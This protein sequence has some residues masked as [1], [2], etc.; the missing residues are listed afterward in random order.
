MSVLSSTLFLLFLTFNTLRPPPPHHWLHH[1]TELF[2]KSPIGKA[3][4]LLASI[5]PDLIPLGATHVQQD[6][7]D[8]RDIF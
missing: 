2:L 7:Q 3:F 1:I 6:G 5:G 8:F 4:D